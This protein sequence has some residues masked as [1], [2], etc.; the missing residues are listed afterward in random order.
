LPAVARAHEHE[1]STG[2]RRGGR[3]VAHDGVD[4]ADSASAC[5]RT[6]KVVPRQVAEHRARELRMTE[7]PRP[8]DR[9][10]EA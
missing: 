9:R 3:R 7:E 2:A 1:A 10:Q 8:L 5:H 4:E 6:G